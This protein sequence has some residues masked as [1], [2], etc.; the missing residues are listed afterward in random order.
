MPLSLIIQVAPG[1]ELM[2]FETSRGTTAS[3]AA[4]VAALAA[5]SSSIRLMAPICILPEVHK[6][7]GEPQRPGGL[8]AHR[9]GT[10]VDLTVPS[11]RASALARRSP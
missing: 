6:V 4:K 2:T 10:Q 11:G 3:A 1:V 8:P 5:G 7:A 9:L